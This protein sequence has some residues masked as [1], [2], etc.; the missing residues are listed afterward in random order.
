M[1]SLIPLFDSQPEPHAGAAP[2]ILQLYQHLEMFSEGDPP[3]N[4]LFVLGR[5][6]GIAPDQNGLWRSELLIIDPPPNLDTRFRLEGD[7]AV[8]LT[9]ED[10]QDG[11]RNTAPA[12]GLAK[13]QTIA[14]GEAH[15]RLGEHFL[16]IYSQQQGAVVHL[17]ATGVLLGGVYGSDAVPPRLA[18][19]SNGAEEL[20]TLRLIA[21]LLK[22][23]HFQLYI[24]R[25][26]ALCRDKL[27]VME[28]LAADVAYL[29]GLRRVLPA[30]AQR[31]EPWESVEII[32]ASL[33]PV[34][35]QSPAAQAMHRA[36]LR[37]LLAVES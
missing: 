32:A 14:G 13:V 23:R 1:S 9:L 33:L 24:P 11:V 34:S 27:A 28:R 31:G 16:D 12:P 3:A 5:S 30:L 21:R 20:D 2:Q 15:V 4:A 22:G 10:P 35:M 6:V 19:N 26:G 25:I 7:V 17:P 29:H 37:T 18:A 36:N 8:L